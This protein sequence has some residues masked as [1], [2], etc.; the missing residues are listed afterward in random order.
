MKKTL[1]FGYTSI[2]AVAFT[3]SFFV[4]LNLFTD[5]FNEP[6]VFIL[7]FTVFIIVCDVQIRRSLHIPA[8]YLI[9]MHF[10]IAVFCLISSRELPNKHIVIITASV[11][12]AL[13][14]MSISSITNASQGSNHAKM[15]TIHFRNQLFLLIIL[16]VSF[17]ILLIP[18]TI[19]I[20]SDLTEFVFIAGNGL[21]KA[22]ELVLKSIEIVVTLIWNWLTKHFTKE[23][24]PEIPEYSATKRRGIIISMPQEMAEIITIISGLA[25]IILIATAVLFSI[26]G[27]SKRPKNRTYRLQTQDFTET[28]QRIKREKPK[29]NS[30]IFRK[31][32]RIKVN[33]ENMQSNEHRI[34]FTMMKLLEAESKCDPSVLTKTPNEMSNE[35]TANFMQWYNETRYTKNFI[36]D[37]A[38]DEAKKVLETMLQKKYNPESTK[39]RL[40]LLN[41]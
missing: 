38:A 36:P 40:S 10:A 37:K 8:F 26:K 20:L 35:T 2:F 5:R 13:I 30:F 18:S 39:I 27:F 12:Y 31:Q 15:T 9:T 22:L 23:Y 16:A 29:R 14:F 41:K 7:L 28:R 17:F 1:T 6:K 3:F 34:R 33:W 24:V 11:V 21:L 25:V 4:I 32:D 19:R